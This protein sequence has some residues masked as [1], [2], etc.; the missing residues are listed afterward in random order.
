[1]PK[2]V[3]TFPGFDDKVSPEAG[4][5]QVR[6][7]KGNCRRRRGV[8]RRARTQVVWIHKKA[9]VVPRRGGRGKSRERG[10]KRRAAA[11]K[12][13]ANRKARR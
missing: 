7:G 10:S 3:W 11:K 1:M 12:R 8:K 5:V 13:A 4:E 9:G 6:S 2:A